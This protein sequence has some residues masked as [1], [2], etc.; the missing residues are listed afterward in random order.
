MYEIDVEKMT[1]GGCASRVKKSVQ[2]IDRD[3]KI[4]VDL[5]AKKVRVETDADVN[6]VAAAI[7]GAGYPATVR[8]V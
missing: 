3:A 2:E 8:P 5:A 6:A 4:E 7:S 1:C